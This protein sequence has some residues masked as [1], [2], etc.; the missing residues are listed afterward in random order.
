MIVDANDINV[1]LYGKSSSLDLDTE[2][3]L[4]QSM[5]IL[6]LIHYLVCLKKL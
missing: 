4:A 2:T 1:E 6:C 3:N 5:E